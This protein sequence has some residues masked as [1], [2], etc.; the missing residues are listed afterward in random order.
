[1]SKM[2][3]RAKSLSRRRKYFEQR[4][5]GTIPALHPTTLKVI[6]VDYQRDAMINDLDEDLRRLPGTLSWYLSLRD[7]AKTHVK[8]MRHAEHNAEEDLSIEIRKEAESE[9]ESLKETEIKVRVKTHERMRAAYRER[10]DAEAMLRGLES[11]VLAIIEKKW[12][13]KAIVDLRKIELNV[14]DSA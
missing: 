4:A 8:N 7:T 3:R 10:M 6:Q 5:A 1:M 2:E 14:S 9:G 12:S 11:A 13:L